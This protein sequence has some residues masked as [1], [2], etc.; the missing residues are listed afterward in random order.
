MILAPGTMI[1]LDPDLHSGSRTNSSMRTNSG[2][3]GRS[4]AENRRAGRD[5]SEKKLELPSARALAPFLKRA[6]AAVRLRGEVSVLLT[7]DAAL[8]KLN[9]Q[10]RGKNKATD[11]LSFPA[12]SPGREKIAGD[13]AISVET[14]RKQ[15]A[16]CGH[17]LATELKVL[18]LHGLL[19]LNGFD[20][21]TDA[22]EMARAEQ[23]LRVRLGLERGLIERV[24]S[25][26]LATG[27]NRKDGAR[28]PMRGSTAREAR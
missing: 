16:A 23:R 28:G 13:L 5:T 14:A 15:G 20:H 19:H 2:S 17:S 27:K 1:L 25:P 21:E 18:M 26:T 8:R 6:Q 7:T 11:V 9:R 12:E 4:G 10:F 22:G 3:P 24:G